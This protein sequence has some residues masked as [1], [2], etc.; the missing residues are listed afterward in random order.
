MCNG[1]STIQVGRLGVFG[2]FGSRPG[3]IFCGFVVRE[4]LEDDLGGQFAKSSGVQAGAAG[5][6]V[7]ECVHGK[8]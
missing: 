5:R 6:C 8:M 2:V 1:A 7:G 4:G 3:K